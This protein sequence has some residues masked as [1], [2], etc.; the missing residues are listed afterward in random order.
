MTNQDRIELLSTLAS[1]R[2][3]DVPYLAQLVKEQLLSEQDSPYQTKI[4]ERDLKVLFE[5]LTNE[6]LASLS[7]AIPISHLPPSYVA[8]RVRKMLPE[9]LKSEVPMDQASE[10]A[11]YKIHSFTKKVFYSF[12]FLFFFF[13]YV[14]HFFK[15]NLL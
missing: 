15:S 13:I 8:V 6:E 1:N 10:E 2:R 5:M 3:H 14:S 11:L 12:S 9:E 7:V 4:S